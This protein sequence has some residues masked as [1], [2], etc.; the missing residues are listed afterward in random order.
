MGP[1]AANILLLICTLVYK[2]TSIYPLIIIGSLLAGLTGGGMT[3]QAMQ[4]SMVTDKAREK[5]GGGVARQP[6]LL[7]IQG[8]ATVS[9]RI[10]IAAGLS[11][12][13]MLIGGLATYLIALIFVGS[14]H[15]LYVD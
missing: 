10:A 4:M 7:D 6:D 13:G 11:S 8:D 9:F 14:W 2:N 3:E 1:T 15:D 12:G 5:V